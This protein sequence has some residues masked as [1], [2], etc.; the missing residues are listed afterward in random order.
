MSFGKY[1][2]DYMTDP[3]I[4]LIAVIEAYNLLGKEV[5]DTNGNFLCI[6][7]IN[8][9]SN[10]WKGN[11]E[12]K[13]KQPTG[14]TRY[15]SLNSNFYSEHGLRYRLIVHPKEGNPSTMPYNV[16]YPYVFRIDGKEVTLKELM[17][18]VDVSYHKAEKEDIWSL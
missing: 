15:L 10:G 16:V 18:G 4:N 3:T 8:E 2:K 12:Y 7:E 17:G 9:I 13:N 6:D 5:L 11:N 14:E 1:Y